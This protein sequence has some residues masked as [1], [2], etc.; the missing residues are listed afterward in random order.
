MRRPLIAAAG[1]LLI[2]GLYVVYWFVLAHLLRQDIDRWTASQ[3]E[4]GYQ[5]AY[6]EPA[7]G[8]FPFA[9]TARMTAPS[10]TAANFHWRWQG[11]DLDLTIRPWAPLDLLFSAP[12]RHRLDV[13][14]DAPHWD[15]LDA[16]GLT[17]ELDIG[18][19]GR[20]QRGRL[21]LSGADLLD[22]RQGRSDAAALAIDARLPWPPP[23]DPSNSA[24]D[25]EATGSGIDIPDNQVSPLGRRVDSVHVVAQLMGM[26]PPA[27]SARQVLAAWRDAGGTLELRQGELAWGPL[28][29]SGNST[30]ALDQNLQA[31]AAGS[32]TVAGFAETLDAF[33]AAGMVPA[34][35]AK[36][37]KF[38]FSALAKPPPGGGRPQVQVPLALQDGV[39][40]M[41]PV[42]LAKVRPIDWSWL[43]P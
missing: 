8:G 16:D 24:I 41:G 19:D 10:A 3:R 30:I 9:V 43:P 1:L 5:I 34:G 18:F 25:L 17:F 28:R 36:L 39:L 37:A 21:A 40:S 4:Q 32:L 27:A 33:V 12:G 31:L 23:G 42:K 15:Q 14:G 13:A 7:I 2:V 29:L 26:P 35:S 6:G 22:S 38:M 11:P 20:V